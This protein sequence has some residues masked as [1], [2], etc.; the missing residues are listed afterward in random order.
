MTW[1]ES[2]FPAMDTPEWAAMNAR[3]WWLIQKKNRGG[4][5]DENEA[6]E[7]NTL[8]GL[9]LKIVDKK[10]PPK[11]RMSVKRFEVMMYGIQVGRDKRA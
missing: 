5:L 3:R 9:V 8:Q 11:G 1:D 6:L 4:G 7:F 10:Y 2:S